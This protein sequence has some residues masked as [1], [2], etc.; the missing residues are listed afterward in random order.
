MCSPGTAA[1]EE[2]LQTDIIDVEVALIRLCSC[3]DVS[4]LIGSLNLAGNTQLVQSIV[5]V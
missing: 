3:K 5:D 1:T 2:A 4:M